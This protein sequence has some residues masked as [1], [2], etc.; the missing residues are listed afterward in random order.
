MY[1]LFVLLVLLV[2]VLGNNFEKVVLLVKSMNLNFVLF[3]IF[4]RVQSLYVVFSIRDMWDKM[5]E[6]V[7]KVFE[8]DVFVVCGD[9]RM[10]FFGFS[11]KYC[12]YI[13]M[14]YYFNVIVDF[15]VVD[16]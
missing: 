11:V 15:E 16:K 3:F 9:G 6:V 12:V 7:W 2:F 14:E 4:L 10:D 13:M 5:K 8:N 1:V